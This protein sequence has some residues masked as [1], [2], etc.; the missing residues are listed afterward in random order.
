MRGKK[1]M[2]Y[3][4]SLKKLQDAESFN[5]RKQIMLPAVFIKHKTA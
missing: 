4:K 5:C 3:I 1:T 2:I